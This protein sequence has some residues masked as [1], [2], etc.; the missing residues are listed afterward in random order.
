M[1]IE[2]VQ[3]I[4][5][6]CRAALNGPLDRNKNKSNSSSNSKYNSKNKTEY[7]PGDIDIFCGCT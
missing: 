7:E 4:L 5:A 6:Q 2:N 3:K 1:H